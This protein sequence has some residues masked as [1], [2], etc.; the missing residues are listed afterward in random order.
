MKS[1]SQPNL[2]HWP[3]ERKAL[4]LTK[5]EPRTVERDSR[6]Y[7]SHKTLV[8]V[9]RLHQ[10]GYMFREIATSYGMVTTWAR[11]QYIRAKKRIERDRED[12]VQ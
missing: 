6:G 9:Y 4:K 10:S 2:L 12:K 5:L 1:P 3:N 11:V 8:E 7:C